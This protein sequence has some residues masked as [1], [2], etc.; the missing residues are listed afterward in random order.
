[1][2]RFDLSRVGVPALAAVLLAA[3]SGGGGGA[4]HAAVPTSPSTAPTTSPVSPAGSGVRV[5]FTINRA[6]PVR[7]TKAKALVGRIASSVR[8]P[9][10]ISRAVAGVAFTVT[11][12]GT[13]KTVY[14]DVS[15]GSSATECTASGTVSTC[16]ILLPTLAATESIQGYEVDQTPTD[17]G[18]VSGLPSY[19]G[20]GFPSGTSILAYAPTTSASATV[21]GGQ[22]V[23]NIAFG[24]VVDNW[25]DETVWMYSDTTTN[26]AADWGQY[27]NQ[28]FGGAVRVVVTGGTPVSN[29]LFPWFEDADGAGYDTQDADT[30]A[31]PF[32]D[33]S[34]TAAPV[35]AV[36]SSSHVLLFP[37]QN[38]NFA[39][40]LPTFPSPGSTPSGYAQVASIPDDSYE[41]DQ[42][43]FTV[44]LYTDGE[45]TAPATVTFSN[46][47]VVGGSNVDTSTATASLVANGST[48]FTVGPYNAVQ[49]YT[50]VPLTVSPTAVSLSLSGTN[51]ATVTGSDY[52]TT[53]NLGVQSGGQN[54]GGADAG[55]FDASG[56]NRD[57]LV[58]PGAFDSATG[59]ETYTI[60][61][62]TIGTCTFNLYDLGMASSDYVY[63]PSQT[64]TV[65][66][67]P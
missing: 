16:T 3:C 55:C 34:G 6:K 50:I 29:G 5:T 22:T 27:E 23:V 30:T 42:E 38:A 49:T 13:M 59:V 33:V 37:Y 19:E 28:G 36:S 7:P 11:A 25:N 48:P 67:G 44:G 26:F 20:D 62:T 43:Y 10:Y 53:T 52:G 46:G 61:G 64:V 31:R 60:T 66:V 17:E 8:T 35:T 41:F 18:T 14:A 51:T 65:T 63:V 58:T 4:L 57:A 47:P 32:Y 12:G 1:M 39:N 9:K 56:N 40:D 21:V 24:P 2:V 54:F 15:A 45:L